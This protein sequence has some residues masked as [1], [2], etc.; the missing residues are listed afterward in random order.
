MPSSLIDTRQDAH[1]HL[2]NLMTQNAANISGN[3]TNITS[4]TTNISNFRQTVLSGTATKSG[5][6][7]VYIPVSEYTACSTVPSLSNSMRLWCNGTFETLILTKDTGAG[8]NITVSVDKCLSGN[9]PSTGGNWTVVRTRAGVPYTAYSLFT[10]DLVADPNDNPIT[11]LA[12]DYVRVS[13]TDTLTNSSIVQATLSVLSRVWELST[14]FTSDPNGMFEDNSGQ[15]FNIQDSGT[16]TGKT[17]GFNS[18]NSSLYGSDKY[19]Y[20][21]GYDSAAELVH[22]YCPLPTSITPC[23]DVDYSIAKVDHWVEQGRYI[24]SKTLAQMD[25]PVSSWEQLKEITISW[26]AGSNDNGGD[27]PDMHRVNAG[28]PNQTGLPTDGYD[29]DYHSREDLYVQFFDNN[30]LPIGERFVLWKPKPDL[31]TAQLNPSRTGGHPPGTPNPFSVLLPLYT[32]PDAGGFSVGAVL[33]LNQYYFTATVINAAHFNTDLALA[34]FF[35]IR[36]TRHTSSSDNYG[37]NYVNLNFL[38]S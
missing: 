30:D 5:T 31:T 35:V 9:N 7:K 19:L 8:N 14:F 15:N 21:N 27:K 2:K 29:G 12:G 1:L 34:K 33:P 6:D 10:I 16:G 28:E 18:Q 3:T 17:G 32:Y 13:I 24:R 22:K 23:V 11:F 20:F 38:S 4:N 36:Q 26:I 37:V 25:A